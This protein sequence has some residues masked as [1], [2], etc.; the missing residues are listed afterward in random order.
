MQE[1][2]EEKKAVKI[3]QH[4]KFVFFLFPF[5]LFK[6]SSSLSNFSFVF[7][8]LSTLLLQRCCMVT[9]SFFV[10]WHLQRKIFGRIFD[11]SDVCALQCESVSGQH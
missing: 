5:L 4:K 10:P 7:V 11:Y 6:C 8:N 3:Q 2:K 1:S 9:G